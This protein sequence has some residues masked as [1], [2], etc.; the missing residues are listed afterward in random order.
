M[1]KLGEMYEAALEISSTGIYL[2]PLKHYIIKLE[3]I[4]SVEELHSALKK[5]CLK[6]VEPEFILNQIYECRQ[7][8]NENIEVYGQRIK[9]LC[10]KYE[11][12]LENSSDVDLV[13]IKQYN[14]KLIIKS[15][16]RGTKTEIR[17]LI[18]TQEFNNLDECITWSSKKEKE[19]KFDKFTQDVEK[20]NNQ[21]EKS[22]NFNEN[23]GNRQK[24]PQNKQFRGRGQFKYPC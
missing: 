3:T 12:A 1:E 5:I 14:E 6:N 4:N 21:M 16:I 13:P 2:P 23:F 8:D 11:G 20:L 22:F 19:I 10:E 17:S 18:L 7:K 24:F 15:F 9:K